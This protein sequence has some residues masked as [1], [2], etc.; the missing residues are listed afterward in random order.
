MNINKSRRD[1]LHKSVVA[2]MGLSLIDPFTANALGK[3]SK[4]KLGLV[5]YQWGKDW[6]LP[7]LR[8]PVRRAGELFS[9]FFVLLTL[10]HWK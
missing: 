10:H 5:T 6:D 1:F 9:H 2:G 3:R 7:T 8:S 4:M